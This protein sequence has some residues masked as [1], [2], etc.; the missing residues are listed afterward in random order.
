MSMCL[1][2]FSKLLEKLAVAR[3][4][5]GG[6]FPLHLVEQSAR[7]LQRL[8]AGSRV[9]GTDCGRLRCWR[10]DEK[11]LGRSRRLVMPAVWCEAA[12]A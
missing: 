1:E 4:V 8:V 2:Q 11:A 10:T 9:G 7:T 12:S 3:E 6:I 5:T